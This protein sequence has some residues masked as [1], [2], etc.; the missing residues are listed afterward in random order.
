MWRLL[1]EEPGEGLVHRTSEDREPIAVD[2]IPREQRERRAERSALSLVPGL[3]V[4][5]LPRHERFSA[6]GHVE[7]RAAELF[8]SQT[9]IGLLE[10]VKGRSFRFPKR[11]QVSRVL[12]P[13]PCR[14]LDPG[15]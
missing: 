15:R 5:V 11:F 7:D 2:V 13:A 10:G 12:I 8:P 3:P 1:W 4:L 9:E 6:L 14:A